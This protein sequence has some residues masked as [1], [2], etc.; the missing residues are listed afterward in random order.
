MKI[1]VGSENPVKITAVRNAFEKYFNEVEAKGTKTDSGVREQPLKLKEIIEGAENRAKK[2]FNACDFSVGIESGIMKFPSESGYMEITIAAIFDGK[3]VFLGTSPL[4]EYPK[5]AV[6]L[7]L[8]GKD[9]INTAFAKL[10]GKEK[11]MG[12]KKGAVGELTK[13]KLDRAEFTE[14]AVIMALMKI[15]SKEFFE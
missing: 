8:K 10:F 6:E 9:D 12:R 4:F 1:K 3:K 11:D 5:K 7:L 2:S 13:G 14:L 15:V